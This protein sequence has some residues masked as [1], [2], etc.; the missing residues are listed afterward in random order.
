MKG[1][2]LNIKCPCG[3]GI[4][5]KNCYGKNRPD[6]NVFLKENRTKL[7]AEHAEKEKEV[8]DF[9]NGLVKD[10]KKLLFL[11]EAK[12]VVSERM[13]TIA[14]F[15]LMEV[16]SNYWSIYN[17]KNETPEERLITWY[18]LFCSSDENKTYKENEY[19]KKLG[20]A[21]LLKLR[22]SLIHF[23]GMS[24]QEEGKYIT[25][26][27]KD[28]D[29]ETFEKYKKGFKKGIAVLKTTDLYEFF[30]DAGLLMLKHFLINIQ[31]SG[32]DEDKKWEH[33]EGINRIHDKFK[34]EGATEILIPTR[35]K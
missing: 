15:V 2:D 24:E 28:I 17:S 20:Y 10:V 11:E 5:Y 14:C 3:S 1:R 35:E 34:K 25:L 4:K 31:K 9:F 13:Q 8:M 19:L 27:S 33:I 6:C 32:Q 26:I 7:S 16:F 21:P 12:G 23:Y 18:K 22:H 29:Q 30:K